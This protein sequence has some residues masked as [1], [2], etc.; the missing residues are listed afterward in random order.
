MPTKLM[1]QKKSGNAKPVSKKPAP[2][3]GR[4]GGGSKKK[5]EAKREWDAELDWEDDV[6]SAS[7]GEDWDE[8]GEGMDVEEEWDDF[9][10][11]GEELDAELDEEEEE[12]GDED[13][14][15]GGQQEDEDEDEDEEDDDDDEGGEDEGGE[16]DEE[17]EED[18]PAPK[19]PK[20]LEESRAARATQKALLQSRKSSKPLY[21]L[22]TRAKQ[23]WE[24]LR[25][26]K[27]PADKRASLLEELMTL[28]KG[29]AKEVIFKHD[30]SRVVQCALKYG[31]QKVREEIAAELKGMWPEIAKAQYGRF[32]VM[33]VLEY[34]S[35]AVRNDV[36]KSFYGKVRKLIRHREAAF[37]LED[38]YT[39]YA[40]GAQRTALLEEFYG[41]EFA[42]F[43]TEG[44]RTID[45]LLTQLPAKKPVILKHLRDSLL[46]ILQKGSA[47][48][49]HLT[50]IHR[51]I[52]EY[53]SLADPKSIP[54]ITELLKDHLVHILHTRDGA[55]V[56][57]LVIAHAGPK[58]RKVIV[59]NMKG[60]I[61]KIAKEQ[62]AHAVL[63]S[64]FECLDDTVFVSKSVISEFVAGGSGPG[65]SFGDLL[66]DKY[67]SRVA[68]FLLCGRNK[69]YQPAYIVKELEDMDSIRA[70]TSKKDDVVKRQQLLDAFAAPLVEVVTER[71][72]ELVRDRSGSQVVVETLR[73]LPANETEGAV[74]AIAALAAGTVESCKKQAGKAGG[75][76]ST[77]NAVK[78][79]KS[80]SDTAKHLS[81]G[82]DMSQHVLTNRSA[83]MAFKELISGPRK[84][85]STSTPPPAPDADT[86]RTTFTQ[87]LLTH[88][89][90]HL[91][92]WLRHCAADPRHT[93]GTAFVIV[94]LVE[95]GVD[96]VRDKVVKSVKGVVGEVR[97]SV[98]G[99]LNEEKEVE[100]KVEG[101]KKRKRK[102]KVEV[103]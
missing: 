45:T 81:E 93:S 73:R 20:T 16:D 13:D 39:N 60:W 61:T 2:S 96:G 57:Q 44:S 100:V 102:G 83:T 88:L 10:G 7:E 63:M 52:Y 53:L 36:I 101:G 3:I 59:K 22:Q 51:A 33:K 18:Q 94:A 77:F 69:A 5:E 86:T 19:K 49:G 38:A 80:E 64:I 8:E 62:Y 43:K 29:K 15:E 65:E 50:I 23:I 71:C 55:R 103:K 12:E 90:P 58:D 30:A 70:T 32:L 82:I 72:G 54:E 14:D 74:K 28:V 34:C 87:N 4:G 47:S 67:A 92:Y 91:P 68:L 46:S 85:A 9:G 84:A 26:K 41:P 79:L 66:R 24:S 21:D 1:K 6:S 76:T 75:D 11:D 95:C 42:L 56:T 27:L 35:P 31:D 99:K 78:T 25:Q 17:D 48:I 98:E 97:K 40:N 89:L 37:V